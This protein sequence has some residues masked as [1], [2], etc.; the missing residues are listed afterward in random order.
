[1]TSTSPLQ[2]D[3]DDSFLKDLPL[4]KKTKMTKNIGSYLRKITS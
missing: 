4:D 2:Y 1:M 3:D